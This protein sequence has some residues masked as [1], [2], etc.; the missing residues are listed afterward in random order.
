[1]YFFLFV[2][3]QFEA[4]TQTF[5][6]KNPRPLRD[7]FVLEGNRG[8]SL[9]LELTPRQYLAPEAFQGTYLI[10]GYIGRHQCYAAIT[11]DNHSVNDS[12]NQKGGGF[13][14]LRV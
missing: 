13:A 6:L 8:R 9:Q 10:I 12:L 14:S 5:L 3:E 2:F 7:G 1:M 4:Q 11:S